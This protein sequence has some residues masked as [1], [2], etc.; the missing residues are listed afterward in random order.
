MNHTEHQI[1]TLELNRANQSIIILILSYG[2]SSLINWAALFKLSLFLNNIHDIF[3]VL[4]HIHV[5][6]IC[7]SQLI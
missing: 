2:L 7:L 5:F 4:N 3:R 1:K 6:L